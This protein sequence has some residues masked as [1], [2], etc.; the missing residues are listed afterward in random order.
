VAQAGHSQ[1][2][3]LHWSHP[4]QPQPSSHTPHSQRASAETAL[5][6]NSQDSPIA[7][8]DSHRHCESRQQ[9]QPTSHDLQQVPIVSVTPVFRSVADAAP[10]AASRGSATYAPTINRNILFLHRFRFVK[11]TVPS[12]ETVISTNNKSAHSD[13]ALGENEAGC[14]EVLMNEPPTRWGTR[15]AIL[16]ATERAIRHGSG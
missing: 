2:S 7:Q 14:Q 8:Q 6:V 11:V 4:Q 9:S 3:Q 10:N 13:P 16:Q 12:P 5:L 1:P 15:S